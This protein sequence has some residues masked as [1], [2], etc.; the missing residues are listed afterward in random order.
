MGSSNGSVASRGW[1]AAVVLLAAVVWSTRW[2]AIAQTGNTEKAMSNEKQLAVELNEYRHGDHIQVHWSK[3]GKASVTL[4]MAGTAAP[5]AWTGTPLKD[6]LAT[7]EKMLSQIRAS[8]N[9]KDFQLKVNWPERAATMVAW[10]ATGEP[11]DLRELRREMEFMTH[12]PYVV[13][14]GALVHGNELES[15]KDYAAAVHAYRGGVDELA[16]LYSSPDLLDDTGMKL[17]LAESQEENGDTKTAA[18]VY[19]RVLESRIHAYS[20]KYRLN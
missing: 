9:G 19:G 1:V 8:K 20:E 4:R 18:T 15:K 17:V 11:S 16:N 6:H 10:N 12:V 3:L 7:V 2:K 5:T 14:K 13:A